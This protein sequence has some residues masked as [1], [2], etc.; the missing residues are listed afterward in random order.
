MDAAVFQLPW[1]GVLEGTALTLRAAGFASVAP[2]I[3]AESV[4]PQ[5][6]AAFGILLA[7]L[8]APIAPAPPVAADWLFVVSTEILIGVLLGFIARLAFEA[9]LFAGT[10]A[11]YPT[12]LAS[13]AMMDPVSQTS[14]TALAVFYQVVGGLLFLATGGLRQVVAGLVRSY[15]VLPAGTA[16]FGGAWV[17]TV[18]HITGQVVVLGF[19]LA[20][21][22]LVAGLLADICLMLIARAVPQMNILVVGAPV[23][24][25]A[26]LV[27]LAFSLHVFA[28]AVA[29]AIDVAGKAAGT[30][31]VALRG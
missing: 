13:A 12:G 28:P 2:I 31:L 23:R 20:A 27:A 17:P 24:T 26:G 30:V 1:Q 9:L 16:H 5:F 11:G 29:E 6:R 4:P 15:Q 25:A 19:R 14:T 21:P 10:F 8:V 7:L 22:L 3:G 18:I